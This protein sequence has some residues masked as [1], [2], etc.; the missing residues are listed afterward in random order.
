MPKNKLLKIG[1]KLIRGEIPELL[2]RGREVLGK[3]SERR[4]TSAGRYD[5]DR[6]SLGTLFS[7]PDLL[8]KG[9]ARD[10]KTRTYPRFFRMIEFRRMA[11]MFPEETR[12]TIKKAEAIL[13]D[14]FPVFGGKT[15]DF[16]SPPDWFYDP[17]ADIRSRPDFY[18]DIEYLDYDAVGDAKIVWEL[19]RLKFIYPLGQ[20]YLLTGIDR[21]ALKAFGFLEDWFKKNPPKSGIN[22]SSSL[23]CAFR[24]Y[25][26]AWMIHLFRDIELLDDRFAEM[27]WYYVYQMADHI[28][29]HLS[30][31][32][33]PNTHLTGEAFGL[34]VAGLIFP[35][36]KKSREFMQTGLKILEDELDNQFTSEGVHAELSSYYHRYSAD[37]YLHTVMLCEMNGIGLAPEYKDKVMR[38]MEY[39]YNLG[40]P[41]GLWPQSGDS[42][43][44]KLTWLEFDDVCDYSAV[45]STAAILFRRPEWYGGLKFETAWL[46]GLPGPDDTLIVE[47]EKPKR[48]SLQYKDSG[49]TILRSED[50]SKY[51]LFDHGKFGFKDPVH[52]HADSLSFELIVAKQPVFI[53]PGTYSYTGDKKLRN[54]FRSAAAH[55]VCLVEESGASDPEGLFGWNY[56]ADAV[57]QKKLMAEGFDFIVA[58]V[59][60]IKA[61]LFS[62]K[63]SVLRVGDDYFIIYDQIQKSEDDK[64]KFLFHTPIA[65]HSF[66]AKSNLVTLET[67]ALKV[68]LKPLIDADYRLKSE[69]GRK[70]PPSGWHSPDYGVLEKITTLIIEPEMDGN[71]NIPFCIFPF[72]KKNEKPRFGEL[73]DGQWA[74][75]F[76]DY[77]DYWKF[78]NN[79]G[80]AFMRL[81]TKGRIHSFF[82]AEAEILKADSK[83]YWEAPPSENL[84]GLI[85]RETLCLWG[86]LCGRC[87]LHIEGIK[88]VW[89]EGRVIKAQQNGEY[90][91]FEI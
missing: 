32:F 6:E 11:E 83:T 56:Y 88:N 30:Y 77:T 49:Y 12:R 47:G 55:N 87:R 90:V 29:S 54:Y 9:L 91:E 75:R 33:S 80:I 84:F 53:D 18:A 26:L 81:N 45:L 71:I 21:Y 59:S 10:F 16:G 15:L 43:G 85:E 20:A 22:W 60:R 79:G 76:C 42:D 44:G 72:V 36:F 38:M 82:R 4:R 46:L 50:E 51:L 62:H 64:A 13:R 7:N 3:M 67:P 37:F 1:S 86:D 14:K 24:I 2:F 40:R 19:S 66:S 27:V 17:L 89:F 28:Q 5:F 52:S 57:L 68:V 78:G 39:L 69:S 70:E 58:S 74:I 61:P 31:Y 8:T 35:E 65:S 73:D 63:R 41:D 25:A 48:K 34:F 23:E